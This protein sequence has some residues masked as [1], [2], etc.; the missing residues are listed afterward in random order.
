MERVFVYGTLRRG[1]CRDLGVRYA[2]ARFVTTGWILGELFNLGDYP[3]VRLGGAAR[4]VGE[5]FEVSEMTLLQL[6]EMEGSEYARVPVVVTGENFSATSCWTYE[7]VERACA[8]CPPIP[9][10]DWFAR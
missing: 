8:G 3:G 2:G 4:V 5:I 10:G 6:D 1:D 9:S 7:V